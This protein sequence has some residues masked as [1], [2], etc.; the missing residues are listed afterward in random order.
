M[1]LSGWLNSSKYNGGRYYQVYWT[2][3]QSVEKNTS[4]ISY[5]VKALGE[6][7]EWYAERT[8]KVVIAGQTVINKTDRVE[9]F[10]GTIKTGTITLTHDDEGKKS[11]SVSIQ[12]AVYTSTV[13]CTGSGTFTLDTIPRKS[14][15]AAGNGT[16]GTAQ[17]LNVTRKSTSFTHTITYKCGTASGT[18][19]TKSSSTSISWTPPLSLASQNTTGTSVSI[20]L[21]I[22]TY[23]GS[24]SVGSNTVTITCTMPASVKPSCTL[25][26]EDVNGIDDIYGSPVQGL[27]AIKITVNATASYGSAIASYAITADGVNYTQNGVTTGLLKTSGSSKVSATVKDKRGRSGSVSYTMNVQAYAAPKVS[28]LAVHRCDQ[29]GTENDQGEYIKA[30]FTAAITSL[31]GKNTAAYVLRYKKST[32]TSFTEVTLSNYAGVYTVTSGEYIFA[33]DSNSSYDIEV[34]ATDRHG[35]ATRATSASTAFTLMNWHKAGT[36]MAIGKVSE[37]VNAL[38][39]GLRAYDEYGLRINNGVA[40]YGGTADP[41]D[42]N[43]TLEH[44]FLTTVNVPTSH[45]WHVIQLFFSNKS[46]TGN[47]VQIAIPYSIDAPIHHRYKYGGNDWS[48]WKTDAEAD[49][50]GWISAVSLLTDDFEAYTSSDY[51]VYRRVGKTVSISGTVKPTAAI[52]GSSTTVPIFTLPEGFRPSVGMFGLCQGSGNAIW[53]CQVNTDGTV[54]FAR[55]RDGTATTKYE[56]AEATTSEWLKLGIT[57]LTA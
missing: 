3:T 8:L 55:H 45:F 4:T 20:T 38:E 30:T 23:S 52:T 57:F 53:M 22:T 19:A 41:I 48:A 49:D 9:R 6:A 34:E 47:R 44:V 36:G 18:I 50:T 33:A 31:N 37:L 24:T 12:A 17:T 28:S 29:D 42:A 26:L 7:G 15:L 51:P 35:T 16:L 25:T 14:T 27:S 43:T 39:I 54:R 1:A 40:S 5:T 46:E 21:T 13:N 11:F 2:A 10:D 32:A 56:F